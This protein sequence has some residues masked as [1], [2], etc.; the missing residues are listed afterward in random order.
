MACSE[1]GIHEVGCAVMIPSLGKDFKFKLNG[2]SSSYTAEVIAM[3]NAMDIVSE[4]WDSINVCFDSLSA[5][6]KLK[7]SLLSVFP[8]VKSYLDP[9]LMD[10]LLKVT[11]LSANGIQ[12]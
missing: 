7:T 1:E 5:L 11:R 4:K 2:L 9:S 3:N 6:T 12:V 10:F 8:F